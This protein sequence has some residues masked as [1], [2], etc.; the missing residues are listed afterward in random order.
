MEWRVKI[1]RSMNGEF[2][3]WVIIA[4][5]IKKDGDN[6]VYDLSWSCASQLLEK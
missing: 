5:L 3:Y 1:S 6:T 2:V 4:S